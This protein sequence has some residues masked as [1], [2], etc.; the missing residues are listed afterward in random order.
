MT[1]P[2]ALH[3]RRV[4]DR[5]ADLLPPTAASRLDWWAHARSRG[6][7]RSFNDQQG[8][9]QIVA[10]LVSTIDFTCAL[11]TGSYRGSSTLMLAELIHAAVA[12]VECRARNQLF[13]SRRLEPY[14]HASS[15]LGD[16]RQFLERRLT[17]GSGP[18]FVYL[19]AHWYDDLPLADE[20]RIIAN[21]GREAVVL[22]D[23]FR[24]ND[25]PGYGYD[26]YGPGK[27][28]DSTYLSSVPE[29]LGWAR[30]VPSLASAQ[31]TGARRGCVVVVHPELAA[32]VGGL[33]SLRRSANAEDLR[34]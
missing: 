14:P 2:R 3:L 8:R 21:S 27:S 6:P 11:E 7:N 1:P 32:L 31:E 30:F 18:A 23:D 25:D 33:P 22:V 4:Y 10:E 9:R 20:L 5:L 17:G 15:E 19:D 13:A 34:P 16:S 24:V 28:L 12:S 26:D 29:I